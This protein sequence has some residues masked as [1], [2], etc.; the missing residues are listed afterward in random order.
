MGVIKRTSG[1]RSLE[2]VCLPAVS[3]RRLGEGRGHRG[4]PVSHPRPPRYGE[5]QCRAHCHVFPSSG[6]SLKMGSAPPMSCSLI[7]GPA[8][9]SEATFQA[10]ITLQT[11]ISGERPV[12]S[13]TR[14]P[15]TRELAGPLTLLLPCALDFARIRG[16][17]TPST[18]SEKN[19]FEDYFCVKLDLSA[20]PPSGQRQN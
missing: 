17:A 4:D 13:D 20:A 18:C 1:R 14:L 8:D 15:Y 10:R 7:G 12:A 5:R 9:Q 11:F 6:A 16:R 3:S 2:E 19:A